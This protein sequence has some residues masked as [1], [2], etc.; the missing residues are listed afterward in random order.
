M[1]LVD[2]NVGILIDLGHLNISSKIYSFNK[3]ECLE[4]ILDNYSDKIKQINISD[5][6]GLK[7]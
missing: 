6:N 4:K 1:S 2:K 3:M 7:D 5:T